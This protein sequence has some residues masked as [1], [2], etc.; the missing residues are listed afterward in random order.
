MLKSIRRTRLAAGLRHLDPGLIAGVADGGPSGIATFSQAGTQFGFSA[1]DQ[2]FC[3][4]FFQDF[5]DNKLPFTCI[6]GLLLL[7]C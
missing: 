5:P 3:V 4:S 6:C 2:S 7:Y 1:G